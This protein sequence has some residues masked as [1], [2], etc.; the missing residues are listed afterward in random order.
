MP[1]SMN[2]TVTGRT[3]VGQLISANVISNITQ[4]FID[5][6]KGVMTIHY[7]STY[8]PKRLELDF[9]LTTTFTDTIAALVNTVVISGS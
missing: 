7:N 5:V 8:G 6:S 4:V 1:V 3:G 2:A 9:V